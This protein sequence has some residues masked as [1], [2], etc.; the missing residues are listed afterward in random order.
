MSS[1]LDQEKQDLRALAKT[2][3]A[4]AAEADPSA[5]EALCRQVAG[6]LES[7]RVRLPAGAAVS[8]YWPKGSEIDPRALMARLAE[9][10]HPIGLPVMVGREKPLLFRAWQEGAALEPVGFGLLEPPSGAPE[11]TPRLLLVPLLAF[12]RA[13]YRLGYGGGFYDRTLQ[14]LRAR[15]HA[16]AIG[17]AYGAQELERV[18]RHEA[19]QPLD[20]IATERETI[21]VAAAG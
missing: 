4:A 13:G 7:G 19:D 18:P 9:A 6:L 14:A 21:A 11:L 10:G 2:R 8:A 16:L 12:D 3:R 1:A 15:G 17:L 5:G 20:W